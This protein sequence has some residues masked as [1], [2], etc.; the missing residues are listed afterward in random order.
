VRKEQLKTLLTTWR[1]DIVPAARGMMTDLFRSAGEVML[2]YADKAESNAIQ[3]RFFEGKRELWMKEEQV[4]SLFN[5]NLFRDLF[6][7]MR[8]AERK[9]APGAEVLSLV[10]K[11]AYERS[12]ALQTIADQAVQH[13]QELYYALAQRLGVVIGGPALELSQ[14]PAGPHQL[15]DVFERSANVLNV[16]R[17]VLLAVYTLFERE[18][19][20][21]SPRWHEELNESLRQAGILPNLKYQVKIKPGQARPDRAK[22]TDSVKGGAPGFGGFIGHA[23]GAADAATRGGG[24]ARPGSAGASYAGAAS[25]PAGAAYG[26]AAGAQTGGRGTAGAAHAGAGGAGYGGAAGTVDLRGD[27]QGT[28]GRDSSLE[29]G[30]Q[31]L[32]RIRELLTARRMRQ[33]PDGT[34]TLRPDP[35]SPAPP[36]AVAAVID[37]PQIQDFAPLPKTGVRETGVRQV[38]V[39]RTLLEKLRRALSTQREQ[40]KDMVGDDKLS[41]VDEDTIDIVGMLF[42]VMLND[43]RLANTVKALLS[44]LHTPYLKLA[45]RDRSFLRHPDHPARRLFDKMVEAG[46]RWVDE[47]DLTRGMYP[48]LQWVVDS[49]AHAP[50]YSAQLF[51]QLEAELSADIQLL[52]ERQQTREVRTLET[53]KGKARLEEAREVAGQTAQAFLTAAAAP[54]RYQDFMTGPWTD[55]LTLLYLRSNGNINTANWQGAQ[56][57]GRR[58]RTFIDGLAA[59]ALPGDD[60]LKALRDELGQRLGDAIPHY[61]TKVQQLFELF[62]AGEEIVLT[63]IPHI[64]AA[65]ATTSTVP[66][67]EI[68]LSKGGKALLKRL[69]QLPPGSWVTFQGED[70]AADQVVKLSWFNP[71][72]ERFLFVD[73]AGAKALV[74]P[75]RELANR[76]D[77]E[78]AQVLHSTG[79]SYVESSLQRALQNLEN[80]T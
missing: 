77:K 28:A 7:F 65:P 73:Q 31:L 19:I 20:R 68:K 13:H 80:R 47:R 79:T 26:G 56:E 41:H 27:S 10:S 39:S 16:E 18:V 25:Q 36:V 38:V 60:D 6:N 69:P 61:E 2:E 3:V 45:V 1:G 5:E 29:L 75:L 21:K 63:D 14:V 57:L 43:D 70:D 42:E 72:T 46:L 34:T 30:D 53:E 67:E 24:A 54:Q 64:A 33:N 37:S 4:V 23:Q 74:M 62:S 32:G 40:I 76:F 44:H 22:T 9:D 78:G 66:P 51:E 11:D 17:E 8:P 50:E 12:L 58:L 49:V 48:K 52:S 55:Y 59:G 15:V 71:K 35:V